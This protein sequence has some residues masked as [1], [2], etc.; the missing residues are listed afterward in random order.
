MIKSKI[1]IEFSLR[2]HLKIIL[3]K[4]L[5]KMKPLFKCELNYLASPHLS[6]IYDGFEK[7]RKSGIVDVTFKETTNTSSKPLLNVLV[8][9]KYKVIYDTLDGLNWIDGSMEDN[10]NYFRNN[11]IADFYFKRSLN[12]DVIDNAPENCRIYPFGLNYTLK[13]DGNYP[14]SL[15]ENLKSLIRNNVIFSNFYNKNHFSS[16]EFEYYPIPSKKTK[17]LF[18]TRLWDPNETSLG[19]LKNERELINNNRIECIEAC[20]KEFGEVFVG[21][22]QRDNYSVNRAKSLLMPFSITN[23]ATFLNTIKRSNICISTTG[24]HNSIGWKFGEYVAASRAIVTEP[25]LY[26]LPGEF[27]N[28]KN[29]LVY[30]NKFELIKNIHKLL[31]SDDYMV[32]MMTNNFQYYNNYVRPDSIVLNT[33][34]KIYENKNYNNI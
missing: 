33:L 8:D 4:I 13:P 15:G 18:L 1:L 30:D 16:K 3:K 14:K 24:L 28:N 17:I 5:L 32:N 6:Q 10:L 31:E 9:N 2:R 29:Y 34:L 20:R 7:L 11:V 22:I 26:D 27:E 12:K 25:L 23:K 21:G 19:H